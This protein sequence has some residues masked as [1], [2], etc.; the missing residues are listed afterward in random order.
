M[1]LTTLTTPDALKTLENALETFLEA[2]AED[3]R[4]RCLFQIHYE[5]SGHVA[6]E[7]ADALV[8]NFPGT[9]PSLCFDDGVLE[10]VQEAW[11]RI[12]GDTAADT[13]YMIFSD[14]EGAVDEDTYD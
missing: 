8:Y 5:Q 14:R 12:L 1:Y 2:V 13:E 4:P 10:P 9:S 11:K 3:S 7:G 6:G